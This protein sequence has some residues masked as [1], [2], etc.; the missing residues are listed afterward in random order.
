MITE[1]MTSKKE[2]AFVEARK[3]ALKKGGDKST[4]KEILEECTAYFQGD[5]LAASTWMNK[6]AMK[7]KDGN[8]LEHT[9]EEM[10]HRMAKE[11][12][13]IENKYKQSSKLNGS[14]A[15]LS[16]YGQ[17]REHLSEEKI[18]DLFSEFKYIVP[19]G[20][21]MSSLGNKNVIASLSNC[22]VLPEIFDSYG[23]IFYTDQQMAQLFKRRCGVGI[24]ISALRPNGAHVS[25]SAGSTSGAIS[26]M[27]RFSKTRRVDA[28]NGYCPSGYR[29][30]YFCEARPLKSDGSKY[31]CSYF[32]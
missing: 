12:A 28:N 2:N 20:S 19:Q 26:F 18:F 14:A 8:I 5:E 23:G 24:D 7:D 4:Y 17:K 25:N 13:R 16:V 30:I 6:Y 21:V 9:P 10:H 27:E 15:S 32:G 11:F 1:E 3:A 31:F 22:I 29:A